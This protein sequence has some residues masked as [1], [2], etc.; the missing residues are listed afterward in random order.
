MVIRQVFLYQI[1]DKKYIHTLVI[2][3]LISYAYRNVFILIIFTDFEIL[4]TTLDSIDI[5]LFNKTSDPVKEEL[6]NMNMSYEVL[7][8]NIQQI[9]EE[10]QKSGVLILNTT[11]CKN[12]IFVLLFL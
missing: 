12:G 6:I 4:S 2:N 8:E 7:V 9:I 5:L 11:N 1:K 3:Y 10:E